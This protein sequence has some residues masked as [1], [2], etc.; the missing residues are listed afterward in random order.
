MCEPH[1]SIVQ[2]P[3]KDDNDN[4][5]GPAV[6]AIPQQAEGWFAWGRRKLGE[7]FHF[8]K[9]GF[10]HSEAL[11][12]LCPLARRI[13][14]PDT[15]YEASWWDRTVRRD[16]PYYGRDYDAQPALD[17][18]IQYARAVSIGNLALLRQFLDRSLRRSNR[19]WVYIDPFTRLL[20][21]E[22]C[23]AF[24]RKL[25]RLLGITSLSALT[26]MLGSVAD[27]KDRLDTVIKV[28][29]G[30]TRRRNWLVPEW[31]DDRALWLP[32]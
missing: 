27:N 23:N 30:F 4:P 13:L 10:G 17:C 19:P 18:A 8:S 20:N 31:A 21:L 3:D 22:G 1:H 11:G 28:M 24:T 16:G 5:T 9:M 14:P 32:G 15:K 25:K 7:W 12:Q 29:L 2:F 26:H 6:E